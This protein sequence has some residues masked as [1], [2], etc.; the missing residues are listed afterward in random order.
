MN[1]R[2]Y[3]FDYGA[4]RTK[5]FKY[6]KIYIKNIERQLKVTKAMSVNKN[7][8]YFVL[9]LFIASYHRNLARWWLMQISA[10]LKCFDNSFCHELYVCIFAVVLYESA[11]CFYCIKSIDNDIRRKN[12][13]WR[14]IVLLHVETKHLYSFELCKNSFFI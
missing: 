12:R 13:I 5:L 11:E 7:C 9:Y 10:E 3:I 8:I 4:M 1:D 14:L 6:P 2:N